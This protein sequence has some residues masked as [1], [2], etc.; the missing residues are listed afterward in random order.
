M[1]R[2]APH[3]T[4]KDIW[5][6]DLA[7]SHVDDMGNKWIVQD[8]DGWWDLPPVA[9]GD[10]ERSYSEDGS[11]YEPGRYSSRPLRMTGKI[12]PPNN[13]NNSANIARQE[14][15][16]RLMLVRKTGLLQV[17]ESP[18][19]GG[20]KQSEVVIVARPLI[21][22]DRL[23]GVLD[24]DIQF[25][26]PDPRKYSVIPT[27]VDA[28]VFTGEGDGRMYDLVYD[29]SY[30]GPQDRSMAVVSN[31]GDYNTYG[32]VRL[33]GP[34]D[35]PGVFHVD[36]GRFIDFPGVRLA[37][38]QYIDINLQEKTIISETGV[39]L[40]ELMGDA[41][42]W[43]QFDTGDNRV[44]ILGAQY[45]TPSPS[46]PDVRN[47]VKDPSYEGSGGDT[48]AR[49]VRR[50]YAPNPSGMLEISTTY[51]RENIFPDRQAQN[52]DA[53]S[54]T[55]EEGRV[56]S[57]VVSLL[58]NGST[59]FPVHDTTAHHYVQMDLKPDTADTPTATLT[60]GSRSSG[61]VVLPQDQWTTVRVDSHVPTSGYDIRLLVPGATASS[62]VQIRNIMVVRSPTPI[63]GDTEYWEPVEGID[64]EGIV[65]A[66]PSEGVF[67]EYYQEPVGWSLPN[68]P[69]SLLRVF[70]GE[71]ASVKL[72]PKSTGSHLIDFGAALVPGKDI[73]YGASAE[74]ITSMSIVDDETG[75]VVNTSVPSHVAVNFL[76]DEPFTPRLQAD[77]SAT[78]GSP[79]RIVSS[80]VT[81]DGGSKIFTENTP[82]DDG[83]LYDHYSAQVPAR[84]LAISMVTSEYPD[85][86][87]PHARKVSTLAHS[88]QGSLEVVYNRIPEDEV[89]PT[90]ITKPIDPIVQ[91]TYYVR[92]KVMSNQATSFDITVMDTGRAEE[93]MTYATTANY[94]MDVSFPFEA[95]QGSKPYLTIT[96]PLGLRDLEFHIDDVGILTE[97]EPYFDGSTEGP[98]EWTG[99]P[100]SSASATIPVV[101]VPEGKMSITYRNAWIG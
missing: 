23:N 60:L 56:K 96:P 66:E 78:E 71:E 33:S 84:E 67:T 16:K 82:S 17:L 3:Q 9:M 47:L 27:T 77:V 90:P 36:S 59:E 14:L 61:E 89:G 57:P 20:G 41:S 28:Y 38:G 83:Y 98:Y 48:V 64:D 8:I 31:I 5:L 95:L 80:M 68:N 26:A 39:S 88:G 55:V 81:Y 37:V 86:M 35:N 72:I 18:E 50:N 54:G 58:H 101:G 52:P 79:R 40:R 45:L 43:F 22:A 11:Y 85:Y 10:V 63:A 30:E 87:H 12:I 53:F 25:R 73:T 76:A 51:L 44:S 74:G 100:N 34:V 91:G 7:F 62:G 70:G 92:A 75:E 19:L 4:R 6:N 97:D 42:R 65:T 46:I 21:K 13:S 24:F 93:V 15:N 94:W 29:R 32:V 1:S 99:A 2:F 49:E 69:D